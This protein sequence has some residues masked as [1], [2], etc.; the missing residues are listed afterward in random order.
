MELLLVELVSMIEK[1][2]ASKAEAGKLIFFQLYKSETF[3]KAEEENNLRKFLEK[4]KKNLDPK[5]PLKQKATI[6]QYIFAL[7]AALEDKKSATLIPSYRETTVLPAVI[8]ERMRLV[9]EKIS[10]D[11]IENITSRCT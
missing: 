2:C 6:Q 9:S 1:N 3:N 5:R 8:Q 7:T 11:L 4:F 10:A